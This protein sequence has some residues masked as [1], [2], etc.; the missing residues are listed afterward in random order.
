M[1]WSLWALRYLRSL[2]HE[3]IEIHRFD[4]NLNSML[5]IWLLLILVI[6]AVLAEVVAVGLLN[7]LLWTNSTHFLLY[8]ARMVN[9]VVEAFVAQI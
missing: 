7:Y 5:T 4:L 2:F 6:A 9:I 1:R 3:I 8:L